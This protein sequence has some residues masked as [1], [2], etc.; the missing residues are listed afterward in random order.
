MTKEKIERI[1]FLARK[2][3]AEGL[4]DAEAM[5]QQ[6]LYAEYLNEVRLSFG[7]TLEHTVIRRPDGREEKL[8]KKKPK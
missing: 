2:K 5:E 7:Q 8:K 6:A 4:T 3:K 1:N